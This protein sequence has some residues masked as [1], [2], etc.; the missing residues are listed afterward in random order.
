[1]G[2][3]LAKKE[4]SKPHFHIGIN[5]L[6]NF[7]FFSEINNTHSAWRGVG[8]P[9]ADVRIFRALL[10]LWA[11][12]PGVRS[13]LPFTSCLV[14]RCCDCSQVPP[15]PELWVGCGFCSV[16]LFESTWNRCGKSLRVSNGCVPLKAGAEGVMADHS[17]AL[18]QMSWGAL[19]KMSTRSQQRKFAFFLLALRYKD[20]TREGVG[21]SDNFTPTFCWQEVSC[22]CFSRSNS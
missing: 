17:V 3:Q 4:S 2:S 1:M 14:L 22:S 21:Q 9:P 15:P 18:C 6:L 8:P 16:F 10:L 7:Y 20:H 12:Y 13:P 11:P 19:L 5:F